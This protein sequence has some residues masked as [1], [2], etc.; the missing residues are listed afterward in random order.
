MPKSLVKVYKLKSAN[1]NR[2]FK[3]IN[4]IDTYVI[5]VLRNSDKME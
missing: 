3:I 5:T 1:V 4:I 2:L